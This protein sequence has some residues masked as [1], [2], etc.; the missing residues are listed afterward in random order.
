MST[1][2]NVDIVKTFEYHFC[3]FKMELYHSA[4][5]FLFNSN[6]QMDTEVMGTH[7][8][9]RR[10]VPWRFYNPSSVLYKL[11]LSRGRNLQ[12]IYFMQ[13]GPTSSKTNERQMAE[14]SKQI[15]LNILG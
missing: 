4:R 11:G 8:S 5:R 1:Y 12:Q 3:L 7:S 13:N 9:K 6:V 15:R 14:S 2:S 10:L